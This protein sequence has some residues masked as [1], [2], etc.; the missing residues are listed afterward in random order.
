MFDVESSLNSEEQVKNK[1][2]NNNKSGHRKRVKDRFK[3]NLL[4]GFSEHEILE[5]LL[6]Y[7]IPRKD[8]KDKAKE[9]IDIFGNIYKVM[10]ADINELVIKGKVTE[11]TAI[12]IKL[13]MEISKK[14]E[15]SKFGEKIKINSSEIAFKYINSILKNYRNENVIIICLNTHNE[16]I[17][18]EIVSKGTIDEA[19]VYIRQVLSIVLLHDAKS[20]ILGHNHPSGN[21]SPSESDLIMTEKL[22]EALSYSGVSLLDHIIVSGNKEEYY[23]FKLKNKI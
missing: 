8:T 13:I 23:S 16:L 22:K 1:K 19:V 3:N 11:N 14:Y 20:I 2:M 7:T 17:H 21:I 4:D 18:Y 6:F 12:L 10:D 5:L 9:L 15:Q